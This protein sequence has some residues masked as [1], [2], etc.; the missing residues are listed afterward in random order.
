MFVTLKSAPH[1][2]THMAT[3][4]CIHLDAIAIDS[5]DPPLSPSLS[6][7]HT[8]LPPAAIRLAIV[9]NANAA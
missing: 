3:A 4:R 2:D 6:Y 8:R 1:A 9:A 7:T 5:H